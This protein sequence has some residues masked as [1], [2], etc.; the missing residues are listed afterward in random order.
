MKKIR[1]YIGAAFFKLGLVIMPF[2]ADASFRYNTNFLRRMEPRTAMAKEK[3]LTVVNEGI[4]GVVPHGPVFHWRAG[5]YFCRGERHV[6]HVWNTENG[7]DLEIPDTEWA[8]ITA[9][10]AVS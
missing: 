2:E 3:P 10:L 1:F 9:S 5:W 8:S 6:V 7:V 4:D